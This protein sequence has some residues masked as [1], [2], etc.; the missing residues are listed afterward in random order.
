MKTWTKY[1]LRFSVFALFVT[2]YIGSN[3]ST[4]Y[5]EDGPT[6]TFENSTGQYATVKLTGSTSLTVD[7]PS[8]QNRTVNVDAGKYYFLVRYGSKPGHYSYSRGDPFTVIRTGTQYSMTTITLH[9]VI[10][11]NYHTRPSSAEEFD[12]L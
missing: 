3:L 4:A 5:A 12:S 2:L 7:V 6:I 1:S 10:N 9:T 11:G 8:G